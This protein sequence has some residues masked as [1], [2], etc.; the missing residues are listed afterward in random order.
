MSK[1]CCC[2]WKLKVTDA[3]FFCSFIGVPTQMCIAFS[4][5]INPHRI[6]VIPK[7]DPNLISA[8]PSVTAHTH[9]QRGRLQL[10]W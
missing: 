1:F 10:S 8:T 3:L 9:E 5:W 7:S 6:S 2:G 4:V